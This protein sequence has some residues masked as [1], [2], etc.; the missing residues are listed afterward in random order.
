MSVTS[1]DNRANNLSNQSEIEAITTEKMMTAIPDEVDEIPT[2]EMPASVADDADEAPASTDEV[3][4]MPTAEMPVSANDEVDQIATAEM[5]ASAPDDID[6]APTAEMPASNPDDIDEVSTASIPALLPDAAKKRKRRPYSKRRRI[7]TL[8]VLAVVLAGVLVP[9]GFLIAYGVSG[10]QTYNELKDQAHDGVN[11]L[12]NVKTIF[13]GVK[14]HPSGFLDT[15]KLT[16]ARKELDAAQTDFE[17][18]QYKIDHTPI[19][20]TV[21]SYLPQFI[22]QIQT[23]R[24]ASRIG[25]DVTHM[26]QE[27]IST[28][29]LLAPTFRGPLLTNSSKPLVTQPMLN[30]VGTTISDLLPRL[31]DIQ[32][33]SRLLTLDS[34]P[35]STAQRD[36]FGQLL[37]L[38]P[39]AETDLEQ[40]LNLLG[41]ANWL[42]GVDSPRTFLVQTMDRAELRPTGGFTGQYGELTI[43]G[44]RVGT[45]S[46]KDISLVEY[47]DNSKTL[48]ME[49]PAQY[50]SWWPFANWGLRD[51]NLSADFPTSAQ[52]AIQQ[53]QLEVGHN[54]DGVILFTPFLIEHILQIIGPIH[55]PGYNDTI[56][57]QNLEDRLHYYQQDNAGIAK[58]VAYQPGDTSTSDRKRFT[59]YLAHLIMDQVRHAPPDELLAIGQEVLHDLKTKDLQVYFSNPQAENLLMQYNDAAQIDRA[60]THDSVY[61][62]QA[63]ISASKASQYVKTTMHDTVTLDANGGATHQLQLRLVYNQLGPVYGYDT[64][65]DYV[66]VYVPPNSKLLSGNGFDTGTPLCG[67]V[68]VQC[69][70]TGVY[71]QDQLVCPSGLYQPGAQA[72][73]INDPDGG[74]WHPLDTI[75]PPTNTS[76]DEPGRAMFGGWVIV[77]KNC[78]MT[79]T[80]SWYVPP[81]AKNYTLQVQKQAGMFPELDLTILPTPGDCAGMGLAAF[82][83]DGIMGEDM[84]FSPTHFKPT[85]HSGSNG[86]Y[87]QPGI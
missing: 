59:G 33:Q 1:P 70:P 7:I 66:R 5:P 60:T 83:Y 65:H 20:Q 18:L 12:L 47:T 16:R 43:N 11:H 54:V 48:G 76:S 34:L 10:Y 21:T 37:Q 72:P 74:R 77:P 27:L 61:V 69:S 19:I 79:V 78:T 51:S 87:P 68:G 14:T 85:Q 36:E 62:V 35:V 80:L 45:F 49:A 28:A 13:T 81:L 38:L 56:T 44:G 17:Q 84:S 2:A 41:A 58:Q 63:N 29:L 22:P 23:A 31:A 6:E 55:V 40:A 73:T 50:R 9:A 3:D 32:Q 46:L 24:A 39:Q 25:V 64:Y 52:I 53:Y 30:L 15:T 4:E 57:A 67:G 82:H 75:G 86:C 26:G 8:A 42:L 71:P